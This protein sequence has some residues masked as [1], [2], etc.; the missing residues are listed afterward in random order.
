LTVAAATTAPTP[1]PKDG[2]QACGAEHAQTNQPCATA[3]V[4]LCLLCSLLVC[5]LLLC[6]CTVECSQRRRQCLLQP[7][8]L[9]SNAAVIIALA[10]C[11][12]QGSLTLCSGSKEGA[13]MGGASKADTC[14]CVFRVRF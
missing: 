13:V 4:V 14:R 11:F 9:F 8:L 12:Q 5:D 7:A 1:T 6:I 2:V 3:A 10:V